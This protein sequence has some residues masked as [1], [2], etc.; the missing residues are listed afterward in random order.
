MKIPI[1]TARDVYKWIDERTGINSILEKILNE[2]IPGGSN[3]AYV[4]GSSL[5]FLF[6]MQIITG[7]CLS[8][9]YSASVSDAWASVY[10][11]QE[12]ATLGWFIRGVHSA[13]ASAMVVMAGMHLLQVFIFGAYKRPR[14]L[15][16]L[17]GLIML[18]IIL[19]FGLTGYLLP[20]DQKGY[21]AT[22]VATSIM[23]TTP[24]IGEY[25]KVI[26]QGGS[27]YG[28]LTLTRFFTLHTIVLPTTLVI[29]ITIHI[30]LFRRHGVTPYYKLGK[31]ELK[32]R[33]QPFWPDQVFK[34]IVFS[35]LIFLV[36]VGIAFWR[37]GAELQSP[38][39]PSSTYL[40][41]PEWY[42]RPL[43]ELLKYFEGELEIVGTIIIPTIAAAFLFSIPF[44]DFKESRLLLDRKPVV[45]LL[46]IGICSVFALTTLSIITDLH[47]PRIV[48][49]REESHKM[50]EKTKRL[51]A[52]GIPAEGGL[53]VL[54]NDPL[55][56]G[57]KLFVENCIVC[58]KLEGKGGEKAPD[59]TGYNSREWLFG[60]FKDPD[61]PRYYGNTGINIMQA[62]D[63][64]DNMIYNI[65]DFLLA[66]SGKQV[67]IDQEAIKKGK[68]LVVDDEDLKCL[69]CHSFNGQG[70][71]LASDLTDYGSDNWLRG[72]IKDPSDVKYFG[73][74]NKMPLFK[75]KLT[76]QQINSI[77]TF[78][79]SLSDHP[80][81]VVRE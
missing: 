14:E 37:H 71:Q 58:H 42:F 5:L 66:Q 74:Q 36:L 48:K 62:I 68:S 15:N 13:G 79:Q 7:I 28:N 17:T 78:L 43:F 47:D 12:R 22:Q 72:L 51:A 80:I 11:I 45:G 54:L 50:A 34:D 31:E 53:A 49:Q 41:R 65:V 20:W 8:A 52:M 27:D 40:A 32:A 75:D 46:F 19:G 4:F 61:D 24:I 64:P 38:A 70:Q 25:L 81:M 26:V 67:S 55:Y 63:L 77:V 59:L 76:E 30:F 33:T 3:W 56:M 69:Y 1:P 6:I 29:F 57:E 73:K 35:L 23:G 2:P 10:F 44:I 60:F 9:Y 21:W 39:D 18:F 16:W